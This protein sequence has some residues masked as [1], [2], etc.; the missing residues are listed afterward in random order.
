MGWGFLLL[1]GLA[2]C[3]C[4]PRYLDRRLDVVVRL[5]IPSRRDRDGKSRGSRDSIAPRFMPPVRT[6]Q[7]PEQRLQHQHQQP[8][9]T[10]T[11]HS[12]QYTVGRQTSRTRTPLCFGKR[13]TGLRPQTARAGVARKQPT[14][15]VVAADNGRRASSTFCCQGRC[16]SPLAAI[17]RPDR[18]Q[19]P[20][21]LSPLDPPHSALA[22]AVALAVPPHFSR[23]LARACLAPRPLAC[24]AACPRLCSGAVMPARPPPPIAHSTAAR[25]LW[26][27]A[28]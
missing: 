25:P 22:L 28:P 19:S 3:L 4:M 5:P 20:Q 11:V 10:Y 13:A 14:R 2:R 17:A 24:T 15:R 18:C 8:H 27:P 16:A 21:A 26:P 23:P 7:A 12:T 1:L 6:V 9:S